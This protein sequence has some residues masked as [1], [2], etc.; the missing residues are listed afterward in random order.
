[1]KK[2]RFALTVL[3]AMLITAS[4]GGGETTAEAPETT[5]TPAA[6]DVTEAVTVGL[7]DDLGAWDFGGDTFDM[8]TRE[9]VL[10]HANL[11]ATETDGDVLNDTIY[12][13]NRRLE[14][15]FNFTFTEDTTAFPTVPTTIHATS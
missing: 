10:I 6:P 12:E 14:Q 1:M 3:L 8:L 9:Y 4:C 13:R 11:N 2:K 15:R 5:G 7:S